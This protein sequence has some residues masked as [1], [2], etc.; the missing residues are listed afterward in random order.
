MGGVRPFNFNGASALPMRRPPAVDPLKPV[1]EGMKSMATSY[2][3]VV[4]SLWQALV[5][6][7]KSRCGLVEPV[8]DER[9]DWNADRS[10]RESLPQEMERA[11]NVSCEVAQRLTRAVSDEYG[12]IAG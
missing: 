7:H 6:T 1:Q 9:P 4:L 12:A 11:E 2:S 10:V 3:K 5:A 8:H